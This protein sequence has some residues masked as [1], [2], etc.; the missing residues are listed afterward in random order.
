MLIIFCFIFMFTMMILYA[1]QSMQLNTAQAIRNV[2]QF[3]K[4]ICTRLFGDVPPVIEYPV[5]IGLNTCGTYIAHEIDIVFQD[6]L[7]DFSSGYIKDVNDNGNFVTYI[8]AVGNFKIN[9]S[10][11]VQK[12]TYIRNKAESVINKHL[13]KRYPDL[14]TLPSLVT[15]N[16]VG[17]D[18]YICLACNENASKEIASFNNRQYVQMKSIVSNNFPVTNQ[19]CY[20]KELEKE[21]QDLD[22]ET[23]A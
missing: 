14:G 17:N 22:N 12:I 15:I 16:Y 8:F 10:D 23:I 7:S 13:H 4:D 21:L 20:D 19:S 6:V 9:V 3:F 5:R 11:E 18:L 2:S 1:K